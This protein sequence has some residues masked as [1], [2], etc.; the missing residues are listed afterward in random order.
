MARKIVQKSPPEETKKDNG[1]DQEKLD[2]K[3]LMINR[4]ALEDI[5]GPVAFARFARGSA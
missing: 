5:R 2:P 4:G 1:L 3:V